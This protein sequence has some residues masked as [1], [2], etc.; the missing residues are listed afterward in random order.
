MTKL[1]DPALSSGKPRRVAMPIY[2]G[3]T[4]MDVAGPLEVFSFA[5]DLGKSDYR[6]VTVRPAA[7]PVT[8]K[9]GVGFM[10]TCARAIWP[11]RSTR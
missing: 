5:N 11:C 3:V 4:P 1:N 2:P 6:L 9:A 10:P 7:G 8:T